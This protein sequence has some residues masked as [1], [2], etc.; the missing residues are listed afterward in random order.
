MGQV[1][2]SISNG[3]QYLNGPSASNQMMFIL[4]ITFHSLITVIH[5][6]T[7]KQSLLLHTS[8]SK[9][10]MKLAHGN[11]GIALVDD[12]RRSIPKEVK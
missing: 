12:V 10:G 4:V 9:S 7:L 8:T 5:V 11:S 2:I 3:G 1:P 6:R